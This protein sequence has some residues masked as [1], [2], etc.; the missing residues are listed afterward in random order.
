MTP[1]LAA[2]QQAGRALFER[3]PKGPVVMLNLL[4]FRATAEYALSPELAPVEPIT[5][6]MAFDLY[7]AHTLPFLAA[8]GGEI[9]FL[10]NGGDYIIGPATERWDLVMLIKQASLQS[11]MAFDS[12]ADYRAGLGHRTAALA[13]SRLLPLTQR[14][15]PSA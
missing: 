14:V 2:T 5:G 3:A 6:A 10:G 7:I 13:D 11:F 8:S 4:R 1:Y 9:L 12:N 15:Q